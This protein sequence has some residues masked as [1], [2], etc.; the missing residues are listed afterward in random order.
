[1]FVFTDSKTF[2]NEPRTKTMTNAEYGRFNMPLICQPNRF[3]Y[4]AIKHNEAKWATLY[5]H[6]QNEYD[7]NGINLQPWSIN[8]CYNVTGDPVV[9]GDFIYST[10]T[11]FTYKNFYSSVFSNFYGKH[12]QR[13]MDVPHFDVFGMFTLVFIGGP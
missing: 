2:G 6:L 7:D 1:M 5:E 9:E 13:V 12:T 4:K 8:P 11:V 3:T 10:R